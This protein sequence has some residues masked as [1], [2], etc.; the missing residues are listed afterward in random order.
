MSDRGDEERGRARGRGGWDE[1]VNGGDG[2]ADAPVNL[3]DRIAWE[4]ERRILSDELAPGDKLPAERTLAADLGTNRNTLREAIRKLEQ[5][6][7]VRVRHGHGVTVQDFRASAEMGVLEPF[8]EHGR[9]PTERTTIMV[10]LLRVRGDLMGTIASF[11]AE[12]CTDEDRARLREIAAA[13]EAAL[14]AYDR[15]ALA[16][17]DVQWLDAVVDAAHSLTLRWLANSVLAVFG[18]F[19]ERFSGFWILDPA[20]PEHLRDVERA[21]ARRDATA[22]RDLVRGYYARTDARVLDLITPALA[23]VDAASPAAP[24]GGGDGTSED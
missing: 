23:E 2:D 8:L 10:D 5:Q 16:H 1:R 12:R 14:V 11:A 19:A 22:A 20:Y 17:G 13:Q 7:L 21:L 9:D 15:F 24:G 4:L 6:G 18:G 3:A